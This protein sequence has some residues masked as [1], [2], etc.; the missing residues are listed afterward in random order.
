LRER[1][2]TSLVPGA[3][4]GAPEY[5]RVGLCGDPSVFREGLV[6]LGSALGDL[7]GAV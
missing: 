3:F 4:F 7:K 5:V 6:R 2:E 1:Y